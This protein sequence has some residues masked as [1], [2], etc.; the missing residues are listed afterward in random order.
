MTDMTSGKTVRERIAALRHWMRENGISACIIPTADPH[1]S[2]YISDHYQSREYITG[3]TG[4]AGTAVIT[5][6][7]AGLWTDSRYWLQAEQ[8]LTGSGIHLMRDG[9]DGTPSLEDWLIQQLAGG[10]HACGN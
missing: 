7:S 4:S 6:G 8:E 3:F 1:M 9:A 10:E 5:D 2:E